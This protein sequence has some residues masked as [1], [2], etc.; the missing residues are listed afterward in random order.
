MSET[1]AYLSS[2]RAAC[3]RCGFEPT[4]EEEQQALTSLRR[5]QTRATQYRGWT[6]ERDERIVL[7]WYTARA[8]DGS[9]RLEGGRTVVAC[10]LLID[11]IEGARYAPASERSYCRHPERCDGRSCREEIACND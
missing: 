8:N 11:R 10:M 6:I 2:Y 1:E 3:E 7:P 5:T 4:A 9:G